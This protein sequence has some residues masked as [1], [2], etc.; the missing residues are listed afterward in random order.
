MSQDAV[1]NNSMKI[2]AA[3]L[4]GFIYDHVMIVG[5]TMLAI[6]SGLIVWADPSLFLPV[7]V[8]DLWFLGY[9]HVI[10]TFTK[11]AGTK[12]DR[13]ENKFFIYYLP[14]LVLGGVYGLYV[15]GGGIWPIVTVYF[16][17]QWY[18]YTRQSYGISMFYRRKAKVENSNTPVKLEHAM[19]WMVPIWGLIH[20][21]GQDFDTFIG[22]PF[23]TPDIPFELSYVAGTLSLLV[24]GAWLF[25]KILDLFEGKFVYAPILFVLSHNL[26]FY[27][28]YVH[29]GDITY[30]WLIANVWHN[31]QYILFVWLFNQNR[32]KGEDKKELS[33]VL[34]WLCQ[35]TPYRTFMYFLAS[36]VVT[37]IV[38]NL[39]GGSLSLISGD[40]AVMLLALQVVVF[41]TLNFHHYIV[42]GYIWKARKKS[43]QKIMKVD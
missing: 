21:C 29:M 28:A 40:D 8:L 6:A 13:A 17:W 24:V 10:S 23:W 12:E 25:T 32:F 30:G 4:D 16:F 11:L 35:K 37:S 41:Q 15:A 34:Y 14:F 42:D 1:A 22:Q 26:I 18:H 36:I 31:A 43:H 3:Y 27:M 7:L 38:Y 20:R 2:R 33:P 19:I 39:L 9:H 5:I